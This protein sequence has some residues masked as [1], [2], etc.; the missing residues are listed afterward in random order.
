MR[1]VNKAIIVGTLGKDPEIRYMPNGKAV[2]N[3]SVATNE[4]WTDKQT[5]ERR[6]ATEWHRVTLFDRG[7]EIAAEYLVKGA[8]CYFEGKIKTRD[9]E[10]D[11]VKRYVTEI[12]ADRI[13]LLG[14][15]NQQRNQSQQQPAGQ[16]EAP[17]P[18]QGNGAPPPRQQGLAVG[19]APDQNDSP[20]NDDIPF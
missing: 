10:K 6:K 16:R 17:P 4:E 19:R 20:F 12:H 11:G 9:Y 18:R 15:G 3:L 8:A 1:G 5:G 14:G 7:A 2:C 13:E